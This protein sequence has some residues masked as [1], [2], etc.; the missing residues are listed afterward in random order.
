MKP[1]Y[2]Y[3]PGDLVA[4]RYRGA[5]EFSIISNIS[6]SFSPLAKGNNL[7]PTDTCK[8]IDG[9]T[10]YDRVMEWSL[11]G[12]RWTYEIACSDP[13]PIRPTPEQIYYLT[14]FGSPGLP[15]V[16]KV[17]AFPAVFAAAW[18]KATQGHSG[19]RQMA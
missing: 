15:N 5:L 8:D 17:E 6:G 14:H 18:G 12:G 2:T 11:L 13:A 7:L 9:K 19:L 10:A 16:S 1:Y 3:K 4:Y